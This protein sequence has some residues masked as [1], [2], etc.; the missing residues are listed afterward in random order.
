MTAE[1]FDIKQIK[2]RTVYQW[3]KAYERNEALDLAVYN[4]AVSIIIGIDRIT[5][6]EWNKIENDLTPR[7]QQQEPAQDSRRVMSR[8]R[9]R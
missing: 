7:A 1:Y 2:G 3:Q 9:R 5:D 4:R 6:D 8:G